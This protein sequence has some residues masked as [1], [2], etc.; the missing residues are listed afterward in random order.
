MKKENITILE[1]CPFHLSDNKIRLLWEIT[2]RCNM[3]C[4]HCLYYSDSSRNTSHADLDFG[5]VKRI[6][7]NISK[8]GRVSSIWISGGEPLV[9]ADIVDVCSEISKYNITP[10]IS[11]NGILL[12]KELI[13]Q[14]W[15]AGVRY[16]HLSIDG[17]SASTHDSLRRTPGAFDKLLKGLEML[18]SS[19]I[20]TGASFMVT[21]HSIGEVR[22]VYEL[23]KSFGLKTLSFYTPAPLGRG[24]SLNSNNFPLS[25]KLSDIIASIEPSNIK[26][27][28]PRI[29]LKSSV[30]AVLPSCKGSN[31]LTI[32]STGNLGACPWLMKSPFSFYVG[33]LLEHSFS[34]LVEKCQNQMQS[35]QENR[36]KTL[37]FCELNCP[38]HYR[39]GR[40]CPALSYANSDSEL[41]NMDP[42]C[43]LIS[44]VL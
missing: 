1:T 8:D 15:N 19:P 11:T 36:M 39:C 10:S 5:N 13:Q 31:F 2:S 17:S 14:F 24:K 22:G 18:A 38:N 6:I 9:R 30:D 43:P 23:A 42:M 12:T 35:F 25:Q 37:R 16:I 4:K 41:Y 3:K 29:H 40:G 7:E 21:E 32:T 28:T 26:I 33:N 20:T 44:N 27:E 34:E